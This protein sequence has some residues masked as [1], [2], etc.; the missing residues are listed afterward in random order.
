M[1]SLTNCSLTYLTTM[2]SLANVTGSLTSGKL[3]EEQRKPLYEFIALKY[4]DGMDW[5]CLEEFFLDTQKEYLKDYTDDE[6][7][8]E[9]EDLV[10][11]EEFEE[12]M[13]K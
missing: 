7:I 9:I 5:K 11:E 1:T 4:L 6:L 10:T 2:T 3:T 8:S 12:L 13:P